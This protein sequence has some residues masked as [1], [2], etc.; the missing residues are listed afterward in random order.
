MS[1]AVEESGIV[2]TAVVSM[3]AG[4]VLLFGAL[5]VYRR[6][7]VAVGNG[8]KPAL[9]KSEWRRFPLILKQKISPNTALYRFSLPA[10]GQS[11]DLPIGQH[12]SVR[13]VLDG[14]EVM[15]SY[16]PTSLPT[17]L[18]YF[19]LVIKVFYYQ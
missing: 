7:S 14:K 13:A 11:L 16:T 4:L 19:D 18:G 6:D 12:V 9:D 17:D 2:V 1:S 8:G 15:R 3:L 5:C 10:K